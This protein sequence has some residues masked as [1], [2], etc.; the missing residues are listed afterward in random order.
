LEDDELIGQ[1]IIRS[2]SFK[3]RLNKTNET[4]KKKKQA[5]PDG[6]EFN[7]E[8]G[9]YENPY[10]IPIPT[11]TPEPTPEGTV[12]INVSV[13]RNSDLEFE[14]GANNQFRS[15]TN[16]V[17]ELI[18]ENQFFK[19]IPIADDEYNDDNNFERSYSFTEPQDTYTVIFGKTISNNIIQFKYKDDNNNWITMR[20]KVESSL[21]GIT[22]NSTNQQEIVIDDTEKTIYFRIIP[23]YKFTSQHIVYGWPPGTGTYT[24]NYITTYPTIEYF[25]YLE[26]FNFGTEINEE[27]EEYYQFW[28]WFAEVGELPENSWSHIKVNNDALMNEKNIKLIARW[29]ENEPEDYEE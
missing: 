19:S 24:V 10:I 14:P 8:T 1:E 26:T 18:F 7:Y 3:E 23:I 4:L 12:N 28:Q 6:T 21:D 11:T 9:K 29:E 16:E 20:G 5:Y 13:Q 17:I 22:F 27:Y 25:E 15:F 2:N